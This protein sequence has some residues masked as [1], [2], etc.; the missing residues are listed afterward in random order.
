[1]NIFCCIM[2][3]C[4]LLASGVRGAH[5]FVYSRFFSPTQDL[6]GLGPEAESALNAALQ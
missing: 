5:F 4:H 6:N 3:A 2:V 1:M